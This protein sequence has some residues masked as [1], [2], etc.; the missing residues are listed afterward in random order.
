MRCVSW[1]AGR[2]RCAECA[3]IEQT[4]RLV[5]ATAIENFKNGARGTDDKDVFGKMMA[6]M[7]ATLADDA[8]IANVS[9]YIKTLPDKPAPATVKRMRITVNSVM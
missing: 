9:A 5:S 3:E 4:R 7:A 2:E 8:A 6:P 1:P